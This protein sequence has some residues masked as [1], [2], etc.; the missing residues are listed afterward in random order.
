M[1]KKK[2]KFKEIKLPQTILSALEKNKYEDLTPIQEAVIPAVQDGLDVLACSQTGSGKT[3]AFLIPILSKLIEN[4]SK[5]AIIVAPTRELAMQIMDNV[6]I[7]C[8]NDKSIARALLIGGASIRDQLLSIQRKPKLIVGTPG[9]INDFLDSEKLKIN[10]F[11]ILVLDEMDRMLDMGFSVQIDEIIKRLPKVKQTMLFSATISKKIEAITQKYLR[12]PL[13]IKIGEQNKAAT[14]VSQEIINVKDSEKFSKLLEKLKENTLFTLVFVRT[15]FGTEKLAAK[16]EKES[17]MAKAIHGDLRQSKRAR[18]IKDFREKKFNVLVATDVA[19]RG[20]DI[21]H[22]DTVINYDLPES[23]EDYIHR[24]GRCSRGLEASGTSISFCG[25]N[26][27]DKLIAIKS[28]MSTGDYEENRSFK[29]N[30]KNKKRH[31]K[32]NKRNL[33]KEFLD[34]YKSKEEPKNREEKKSK[35]KNLKKIFNLKRGKEFSEKKS[36]YNR[37][38]D[39]KSSYNKNPDRQSSYGKKNSSDKNFSSDKTSNFSKSNG[40]KFSSDRKSFSDKPFSKNKKRSGGSGYDIERL[41][42]NKSFSG[43][44]LSSY[45]V[46]NEVSG[47]RKKKMKALPN[48]SKKD[49]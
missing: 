44:R 23:P 36:S 29:K 43:K 39:R 40:K 32:D 6:K 27:G 5:K 10:D 9:R 20:L 16:L 45:F 2:M 30:D 49:R 12:E 15:K 3:G 19:A 21:H 35:F 48:T 4:E 46:S 34:G 22:I 24:I 26:D 8:E 11:D 37:D 47:R 31:K 25:E 13:I 18:I 41:M 38:S 42:P 14:N 33:E 7:F 17:I 28:L 1:I